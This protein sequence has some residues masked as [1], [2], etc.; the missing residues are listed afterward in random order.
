MSLPSQSPRS[1]APSRTHM[2]SH[3]RQGLP[4]RPIVIVGFIVVAGVGGAW[5]FTRGDDRDTSPLG[6]ETATA[7]DQL[8]EDPFASRGSLQ[9]EPK[10]GNLTNRQPRG[11]ETRGAEPPG[12]IV[13]GGGRVGLSWGDPLRSNNPGRWE[14]ALRRLPRSQRNQP[15][16]QNNGLPDRRVCLIAQSG[17][18]S[19][20]LRPTTRWLHG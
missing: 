8:L 2:R 5:W 7:E 4:F 6:P 19:N 14:R 11:S 12:V 9:T 18:L 10:T 13:Q 15:R 17:R 1:T 20:G 3:R 16:K